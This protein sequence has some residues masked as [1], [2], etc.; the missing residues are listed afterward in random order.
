ML[1]M[2]L[3]AG[4]STIAKAVSAMFSPLLGVNGLLKQA[5]NTRGHVIMRD[6]R[7]DATQYTEQMEQ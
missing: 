7:R 6:T 1:R 2:P 4:Q 3:D 5:R